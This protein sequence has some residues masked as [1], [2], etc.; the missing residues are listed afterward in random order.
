[1]TSEES[2]VRLRRSATG[3]RART[4]GCPDEHLIAGFAEGRLGDPDHTRIEGHIAD[5]GACASLVGELSRQP[6]GAA[7]EAVPELTLARARRLGAGGTG[8]WMTFLP[9]LA[10]AA[11]AVVCISVLIQF[12]RVDSPDDANA[13]RTTRSMTT[14]RASL[15]VLSPAAGASLEPGS[16]DV[17]WTG[18]AAARYYD[19]RIVTD[20]GEIVSEQRVSTTEWRPGDGV[21]LAPGADY[22]VR[23]DAVVAG[24]RSVSSEHVPFRI[25]E[26]E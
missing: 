22:F 12:I 21:E 26:R 14:G 18:V 2:E 17:R 8:S 25:L 24:A 20:A 13:H 15:Q 16:L 11:F 3:S 4:P 1:M 10:A 7:T 6:V 9:H 23:V 5:C 19:V